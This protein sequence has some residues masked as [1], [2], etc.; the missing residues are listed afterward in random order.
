VD[1][2]ACNE[3]PPEEKETQMFNQ[4]EDHLFTART[5]IIAVV[6]IIVTLLLI[7]I[8]HA[9]FDAYLYMQSIHFPPS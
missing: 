6:T 8:A 1:F 9:G 5:A 3:T 7:A 2:I 4:S